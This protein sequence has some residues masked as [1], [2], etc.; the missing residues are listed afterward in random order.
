MR[1]RRPKLSISL[2]VLVFAL[3]ASSFASAT[4]KH[5]TKKPAVPET[6]VEVVPPPPPPP[7]PRPEQMPAV[8]PQVSYQDGKLTIIARNST[9]GDILRAVHVKTGASIELA[10]SAPERVV[11]QFGPGP[12]RDVMTSL[13]NGS[14]FNYV[15][16]GSE[17]H[18]EQLERLILTAKAGGDGPSSP[19][20]PPQPV[21]A[22]NEPVPIQPEPDAQEA[23]ASDD[24]SDDASA[25]ADQADQQAT[26][27]QQQGQQV[28]QPNAKTPEQLLLEMQR[29]QQLQQQQQQQPGGVAP[30]PGQGF[31]PAPPGVAPQAPPH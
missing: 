12:S 11:G 30:T 23:N 25:D 31:P 24:L 15:M 14:H 16:L 26:D 28:G 10:G 8:P 1:L 6:T 19:G 13:L 3:S 4:Q 7:P 5:V 20:V 22:Q 9:L 2:S 21:Q 29:Q 18:P 27:D 17:A